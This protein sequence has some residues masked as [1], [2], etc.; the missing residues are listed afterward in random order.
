MMSLNLED[1]RTPM[2]RLGVKSHGPYVADQRSQTIKLVVMGESVWLEGFYDH[3]AEEIAE[4]FAGAIDARSDLLPSLVVRMVR[5][6]IQAP[7][8]AGIT[9]VRHRASLRRKTRFLDGSEFKQ[10]SQLRDVSII[11]ESPGLACHEVDEV[12]L[13]TTPDVAMIIGSAPPP[14]LLSDI[15]ENWLLWRAREAGLV[16]AHASG[17]LRGGAVEMFVGSSGDGK[18]TELLRQVSAGA[19]YFANDRIALRVEGDLL[20][21]RSFPEPINIG[22]GTIQALGLD[23]PTFDLDELGAIR[24]FASEVSARWN[25]DFYTWYPV[26]RIFARDRNSL[27]QNIY[28]D[29]D[30]DHPFWNRALRPRDLEDRPRI[31]TAI[32]ARLIVSKPVPRDQ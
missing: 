6:G 26:T 5:C 19:R 4:W 20:L 7:R 9:T 14:L 12:L 29:G 23:L 2:A 10:A 27:E 15:M 24:L 13:V 25:P 3:E 18:T 22:T 1:S 30:P 8:G 31:E 32:N 21:G 17:W 16:M 11:S 28:W